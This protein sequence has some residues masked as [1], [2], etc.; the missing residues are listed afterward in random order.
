MIYRIIQWVRLPVDAHIDVEAAL[1][2]LFAVI[3]EVL[4]WAQPNRVDQKLLVACIQN[5]LCYIYW[6]DVILENQVVKGMASVYV[7]TFDHLLKE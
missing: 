3:S 7:V 2:K 1:S 5:I 4:D 6:D